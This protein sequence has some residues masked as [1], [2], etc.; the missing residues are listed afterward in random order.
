MAGSMAPLLKEASFIPLQPQNTTWTGGNALAKECCDR[1][2]PGDTWSDF[3]RVQ[4]VAG[5]ERLLAVSA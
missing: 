4:R 3:D 1:P 2:N 5:G